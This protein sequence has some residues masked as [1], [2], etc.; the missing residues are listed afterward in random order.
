MKQ[1]MDDVYE[2]KVNTFLVILSKYIYKLHTKCIYYNK[3]NIFRMYGIKYIL[4]I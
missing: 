4:I 2:I 1:T 3:E